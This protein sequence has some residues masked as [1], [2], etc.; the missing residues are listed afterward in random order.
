MIKDKVFRKALATQSPR[1]FFGTYL[2]HYIQIPFADFHFEMF[3]LQEEPK[4]RTIVIMGARNSAKSTIMNTNL[5]LWSI[6]GAPQKKMV[7]ILGATQVSA[8]KHFVDLRTELEQNK[9]LRSDLGPLQEKDSPWGA[10][11][12]IP[13]YDAHITFASTE[14]S[15]RGIKHGPYRP[16]LFIADDLEDDESVRTFEGRNKL[17]DWLTKV[18]LPAGDEKNTRLVVLGTLLHEDSLMMR[19]KKEIACGT[20]EGAYRE[21]PLLDEFGHALWKAKYPDQTAIDA[22]RMYIGN[23]R[24]FTQEFLLKLVSS[25]DRVIQPEWIKTYPTTPPLDRAHEYRGTFLSLDPASSLEDGRDKTAIVIGRMFGYGED[26]RIYILPNSVNAQIDFTTSL[27]TAKTLSSV[28]GDG[29]KANIYVENNQSQRWLAEMLRKDG[30][31]GIEVHAGIAKRSR[32][33]MTSPSVKKHTVVFPEKG[34]ED[35]ITQ[36]TGFGNERYDDLADAFSMLVAELVKLNH[37]R[38]RPIP[39]QISFPPP[40]WMTRQF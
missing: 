3:K 27:D 35:L 6:L 7:V 22:A 13:K 20:R 38:P 40:R 30:Y 10:T 18:V 17:Y 29:G 21:Y 37:P 31:P 1:L 9:L 24:A 34:C 14:Q 2:G 23:D 5:A 16:D 26:M 36:I 19:L 28:Y 15:I 39:D 12:V 11:L 25:T 32:L 8:K 4:N 33:L